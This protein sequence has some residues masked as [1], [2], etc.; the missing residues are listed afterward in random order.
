MLHNCFCNESSKGRLLATKEDSYAFPAWLSRVV[1][2]DVHV[3][4]HRPQARVMKGVGL[5]VDPTNQVQA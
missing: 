2:E 3:F 5:K 1:D 4:I